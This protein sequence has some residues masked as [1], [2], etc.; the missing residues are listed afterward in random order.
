MCDKPDRVRNGPVSDVL[1][2]RAADVTDARTCAPLVLASGAREF[3]FFLGESP[4]RCIAFLAFAFA[5]KHGRFSWRR[6][7]VAVSEDGIVRAVL[8]VH[9][10]RR[11]MW[12]DMHVAWMLIRFFGFVCTVR[13][14]LRG[15]ILESELPSPTRKQILIAHCAVEEAWRGQGVFN[16]LFD[17]AMQAGPLRNRPGREIVL[18]VLASNVRARAL[19]ERLGFAETRKY[20]RR[21]A[22]LPLELVSIRMRFDVKER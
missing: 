19:Y 4:G 15:L 14:L 11:V 7:R 3:A 21:S 13:M 6:H 16:A 10:G 9:D 20:R 2:Y 22:R 17:D 12:D 18:D 1:G 8:A 5:S